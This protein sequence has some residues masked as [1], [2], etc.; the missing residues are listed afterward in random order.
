MDR[1]EFIKNSIV[2]GGV[3]IGYGRWMRP[4]SNSAVAH[5]GLL[6]PPGAL[7]EAEFL[8]RCIQCMRCVDT[9]PNNAILTYSSALNKPLQDTPVIKPRR[10]SCMLCNSVEGDYLKCTSVCP[11][12]ALQKV[13]KD[14]ET[15]QNKVSMGTAEIDQAL[16]YS[17]NNWICGTCYRACPFPGKAMTL[18]MFEKPEVQP[19]VCVGC[20]ACERA[21]IRYPQAIRVKK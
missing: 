5:A 4:L 6:R 9:C 1:R 3:L 21:C 15:I 19:D 7:P 13:H 17:Y 20:G 2:V 8:S 16:C 12:G 18:G 14:P 11:T 10:Q